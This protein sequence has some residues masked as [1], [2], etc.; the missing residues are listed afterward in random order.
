[1]FP[2]LSARADL[3][4]GR[5]GN[6]A[7]NRLAAGPRTSF[8]RLSGDSPSMF[9]S[10]LAPHLFFVHIFICVQIMIVEVVE[11]LYYLE[12]ISVSKTFW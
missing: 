6:P 3:S 9:M 10:I 12:M 5:A 7:A 8:L 1:M 11:V 2:H 4:V